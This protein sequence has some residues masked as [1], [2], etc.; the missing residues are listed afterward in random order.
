VRLAA[1]TQ[2]RNFT[3]RR[4][5][6]LEPARVDTPPPWWREVRSQLGQ[7]AALPAGTTG[8]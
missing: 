6:A 8:G 2:V 1:E 7:P 5:A 3:P 4:G